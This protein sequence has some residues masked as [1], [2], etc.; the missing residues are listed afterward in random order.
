MYKQ[1]ERSPGLC[2]AETY[3]TGR[4]PV[5]NRSQFMQVFR[6]GKQRLMD[7]ESDSNALKGLVFLCLTLV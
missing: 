4:E 3:C 5:P 2:A 6:S 7:D 1:S